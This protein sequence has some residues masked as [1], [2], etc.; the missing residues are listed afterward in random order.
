VLELELSPLAGGII[1]LSVV[2]P[3]EGAG[4]AGGAVGALVLS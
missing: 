3:V 2:V 4:F 1:V